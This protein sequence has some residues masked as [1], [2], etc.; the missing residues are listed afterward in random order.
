LEVPKVKHF[1][2]LGIVIARSGWGV[3]DA[4]FAFKCGPHGGHKAQRLI[5]QGG[6]VGS[7]NHAH[8]DSNSFQLYAMGQLLA[9]DDGYCS[10]QR[11]SHHN[12]VLINGI[13]QEGDSRPYFVGTG[14]TYACLPYERCGRILAV[15]TAGP[16]GTVYMLGSAAG[17][18][19]KTAGLRRFRRHVCLRSLA[20]DN[21]IV[22]IVDE[23]EAD[24]PSTFTWLLHTDGEAG[25]RDAPACW[26][27]KQG[28][29]KLRLY[30]VRPVRTDVTC[31]PEKLPLKAGRE[32]VRT[33]AIRNA[34]PAVDALF[35]TVLHATRES[36]TAV[37]D[38]RVEEGPAAVKV[39][40]KM[41]WGTYHPLVFSRTP[42]GLVFDGI[43]R[44]HP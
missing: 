9:R 11:T 32:T 42:D 25:P 34:V 31:V 13:G 35:I 12:T 16:E 4:L 21:L 23:L 3:H 41:T 19:P 28:R 44:W 20:A 1:K 17:T 40:P 29:A 43:G 15:Q 10:V 30:P 2:D 26:E 24:V 14:G 37:L 18:Y 39:G 7:Y 22:V 27:V 8:P 6:L 36:A 5:E 33:L 38:V